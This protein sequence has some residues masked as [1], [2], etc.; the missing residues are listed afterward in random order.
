MYGG[1]EEKHEAHKAE[2]CDSNRK[3]A[4][5]GRDWLGLACLGLTWLGLACLGVED[6][7]ND[8]SWEISM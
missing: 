6:P 5:I 1:D 7:I 2:L 3:N 8:I 4:S